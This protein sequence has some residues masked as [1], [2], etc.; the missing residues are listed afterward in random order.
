MFVGELG[1]GVHGQAYMWA[2]LTSK[3]RLEF[4]MCFNVFQDW[5]AQETSVLN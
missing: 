1:L 2:S 4:S 3:L 5:L